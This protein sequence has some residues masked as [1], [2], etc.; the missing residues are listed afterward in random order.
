MAGYRF[1][2]AL[3]L[4]DIVNA[5]NYPT[6]VADRFSKQYAMSKQGPWNGVARIS[7][8]SLRAPRRKTILRDSPGTAGTARTDLT[9]LNPES[10]ELLE[11]TSKGLEGEYTT[12]ERSRIRQLIRSLEGLGSEKL[13]LSDPSINDY[14]RVSFVE[15]GK[16]PNAGTP[17]GGGFRYGI[18]RAFF[19]TEDTFQHIVNGTVAVNM[20]YFTLL[21]C[22][23]GCVTLR[24]DIEKMTDAERQSLCLRCFRKPQPAASPPQTPP[25]FHSLR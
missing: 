10:K 5:F 2:I 18:G 22:I 23:K 6:L 24:G 21:G 17:V 7:C 1:C 19:R 14:Y 4:L 15:E 13:Y 16:G 20:L 8:P 3:V 12:E 9:D 25:P 11:I